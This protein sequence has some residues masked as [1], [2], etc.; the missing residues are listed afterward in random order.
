M[1]NAETK[2]KRIRENFWDTV[3]APY[4]D[5]EL[6]LWM[7]IVFGFIWAISILNGIFYGVRASYLIALGIM[8]ALLFGNIAVCRRHYR[9]WI[10]VVTFTLLSIPIFY[11]FT[12][13]ALGTSVYCSRCCFPAGIVFI[14]RESKQ[15]SIINP[16]HLAAMIRC[17]GLTWNIGG[18]YLRKKCNA[19]SSSVCVPVFMAYLLM[20]SIQYLLGG[21]AETAGTHGRRKCKRRK[22]KAGNVHA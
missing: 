7:K 20:Y 1:K 2:A 11:V 8:V 10:D 14:L 22:G 5:R 9:R 12:T 16:F 18:R 3:N 6:A 4:E 13:R 17:S 19:S 15:F 21:E